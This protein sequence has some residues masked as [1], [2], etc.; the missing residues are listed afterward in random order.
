VKDDIVLHENIN[1]HTFSLNSDHLSLNNLS[2]AKMNPP[3]FIIIGAMKC[4]TSTLHEQL[5]QQPGIFMTCLKEPNFFSD[6]EQYFKG[7]EWYRS[8]FQE[9][10]PGDLCGES[11]THY[12]KLPTY[13]K[14]VERL[15]K[16]C[17]DVKL[18]YIMRHPIDRLIA[19]YIHE[20][21]ERKISVEIDRALQSHPELL[22][23]S[24]YSKQLEPYI[25]IF[26]KQQILPIFFERLI[27]SSQDEIE[28]IGQFINY[29][30]KPTWQ[31]TLQAQNVS[32]ERM[33]KSAWRNFLVEAPL[34]KD[35]RQ[36]FIPQSW[37]D[38]LKPFW[39]MQEKPQIAPQ[40]QRE[41]QAIFDAD[42][43][44]LSSWFGIELCCDR[45]KS[46]VREQ[47]VNWRE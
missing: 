22:E 2:K 20:W 25:D 16:Y 32:A 26:G 38:S 33:R 19:Q 30:H 40:R 7:I 10:M 9:A 13:P 23:Y 43:A 37:R 39:M 11:S 34:L 28:R 6:D 14:T 47:A 29:P 24:L 31:N 44:R 41:L 35:I 18:I 36:N 3:N 42:L 21:T 4:A 12:T 45:F 46:T 1:R 5:A 17:P 15:A 8:Q 27:Q